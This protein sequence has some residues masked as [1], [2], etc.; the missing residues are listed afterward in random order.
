M[1]TLK[2][3]ILFYN[4]SS[5]LIRPGAKIYAF[6]SVATTTPKKTY[7]SSS[8]AVENAHPVV[9]DG[10]GVFPPI[11]LESGGYRIVWKD[12]D[13]VEF[14]AR[15]DIN[16]AETTILST[17]D[18]YFD[19]LTNL[20]LGVS[21]NG[22]SIDL[23][24]GQVARTVGNVTTTDG[25][26]AE[27]LVVAA[28]TGTADD[29]LFADLGNGLQVQRLFNQ[30]YTDRNLAEI[31]TAGGVAQQ[32][33]R[34]NLDIDSEFLSEA[35]NLSDLAS[36]ATSRVNLG[37]ASQTLFTGDKQT[38]V[39]ADLTGGQWPTGGMTVY[40]AATAAAAITSINST[41]FVPGST[42]I[43]RNNTFM[44]AFVSSTAM[45]Q[46]VFFLS[47]GAET[48]D[49]NILDGAGVFVSKAYIRQ[50]DT[51]VSVGL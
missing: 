11:W 46:L 2:Q 5:G 39:K 19:D 23:I 37:I 42:S 7:T 29:D 26:G 9:A 30:L 14:Q 50:I 40:Y 44:T 1:A 12:Q 8:L 18:F 17:S 31:A 27:W 16:I 45:H 20:K 34:D 22:T 21:I 41:F 10:A 35:N 47:P 4:D 43:A 28:G 36:A 24:I 49:V 51:V 48:L 38:I 3:E 25:L 6:D 13:D 15:N 33:A 32:A